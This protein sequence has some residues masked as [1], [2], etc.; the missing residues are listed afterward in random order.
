[1][2]VGMVGGS[3]FAKIRLNPAATFRVL[4]CA[5]VS[6]LFFFFSSRRRHTRSLCDWSSDV[7]LFRSLDLGFGVGKTTLVG[8]VS[9][10][11]PLTTEAVMT[12]AGQGVDDASKVPGK[13]TTTVAMDFGRRSEERRVGKEC[14]SRWSPYH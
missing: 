3:E 13:E 7:L 1:M 14:R 5:V 8:A 2:F 11:E 6:F 10:I 12:S 9:E 4:F